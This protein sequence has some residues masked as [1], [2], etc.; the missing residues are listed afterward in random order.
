MLLSMTGFSSL[1]A[2][3]PHE[4]EFLNVSITIKSL[5]ARFFEGSCRLPHLFAQWELPCNKLLKE[6]LIRGS[7]Y[8]TINVSNAQGVIITITPA[9]RLVEGYVKALRD[10]QKE[11]DLGGTLEIRDILTMPDIF[12]RTE[13]ALDPATGKGLLTLVE[14]AI[15]LLIQTRTKEGQALEADV[16]GR[17]VALKE[18]LTTIEPRAQKVVEER[19]AKILATLKTFTGE[20]A[21]EQAEQPL[22]FV[23]SQ[24]EKLDIHEEIVRLKAHI[25]SFEQ[26]LASPDVEKGK[27]LDFTT[28]ELLRE[29]S[30]LT[31]K[32]SDAQLSNLGIAFKVE[33]E[34]IREQVQNIV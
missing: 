12:E 33:L 27:K 30:T 31:A 17:L 32:A 10:M 25:A 7:V 22:S 18:L 24:I 4:D 26:C 13:K 11:L 29:I 15:E 3:L 2:P 34:K 28:Q 21:H 23:F 9:T 14:R 1:M 6:K 19:K 8:C 5:N 20:M 16:R